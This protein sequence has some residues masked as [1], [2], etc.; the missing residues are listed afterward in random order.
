MSLSNRL[1]DF[2]GIEHPIVLAPMAEISGG[3]LAAAVTRAGGLGLL[4]G[5]YGDADWLRREFALADDARVG[6]GFITWSLARHPEVLDVALRRRP[7]AIMLSFGDPAAFAGA[8]RDAGVPLICQV[9][10]LAQAHHALRSGADVLVAQGSEA[11]GH[12]MTSR[13]TLTFVPAVV[14]LVTEGSPETFVLAAGGIA[15]G[16]GL[17]AALALGADGVLVGTRFWA[18]AEALVSPRAQQH[19]IHASGEDTIRTRVYDVVRQLDWPAHYDERALRNTFLQRWHGNEAELLADLPE[20]VATFQAALAAE[21]FDV[22]HILAGEAVGLIHDV[23]A[24]G[25]IVRH[26]VCDATRILNRP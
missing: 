24:A 26:M 14:D 25:D 23:A 7:A 2:F 17:A 15:D 5:G 6:C 19:A 16:R 3:R 1:T 9:Q 22:A 21:D 13:S 20:A 12:G 11:G 18:S 4:G 10:T 8:I